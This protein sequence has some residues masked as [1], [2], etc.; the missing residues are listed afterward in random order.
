MKQSEGMGINNKGNV[1]K[2]EASVN[3]T[4][5]RLVCI[6]CGPSPTPFSYFG[7]TPAYCDSI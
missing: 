3:M 7:Q 4:G 5:L 2:L 6:S 1:T